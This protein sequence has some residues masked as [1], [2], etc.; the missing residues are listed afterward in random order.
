MSFRNF[1]LF[2]EVAECRNFSKAADRQGVSQ[3]TV[4]Q[5]VAHLEKQ[6]GIELIDRSHRL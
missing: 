5:A 3:S 1:E 4:S 2:C 6:L